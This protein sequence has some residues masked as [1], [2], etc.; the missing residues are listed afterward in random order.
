MKYVLIVWIIILAYTYLNKD[1]RL[2]LKQSINGLYKAEQS[3]EYTLIGVDLAT[4]DDGDCSVV[5]KSR[6][7]N[8]KLIF[9]E[10]IPYEGYIKNHFSCDSI[11]FNTNESYVV[12][13]GKSIDEETCNEKVD[14]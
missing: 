4:N 2:K 1:N 9:E 11:T 14:T 3:D 12:K 13:G 5:I 6:S 10:C 7:E 8:G